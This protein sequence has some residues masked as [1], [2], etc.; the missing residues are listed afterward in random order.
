MPFKMRK[1]IF[2]PEKRELKKCVPVLP[3]IFTPVIGSILIF[4]LALLLLSLQSLLLVLL[5]LLF[6][7]LFD[8]FLF[9]IVNIV[10]P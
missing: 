3:K 10:L 9:M 6:S 7:L 8:N 4:Y 1:I 2:Y 5:L